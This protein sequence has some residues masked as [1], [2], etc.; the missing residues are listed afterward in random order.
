MCRCVL[1][2]LFIATAQAGLSAPASPAKLQIRLETYLT[3]YTSHRGSPFKAV[4]I[5]PLVEN[6][7]ILIP[8]RSVVYGTVRRATPVRLGIIHERAGLDLNFLRYKTPGGREFPLSAK[9]AAID[10]AREQVT[11]KGRIKGVLAAQAPDEVFNGVWDKPSFGMFFHSLEG[12]RGLSY[13]ISETWPMGPVGPAVLMGVRCFLIRFP[14][15]EIHLPPGTDMT[16][17]VDKANT[18]FAPKPDPPALEPPAALAEWLR[19][20]PSAVEKPD[21]RHVADTINLAF[22]GSRQQLRNAFRVSGWYRPV[23]KTFK[24]FSRFCL[25][26]DRKKRYPRAPVSTLLYRGKPPDLVF[27]KSLDSVAKRDHVRIWSTGFSHGREIWLG[28]ATHDIGVRFNFRTFLFTHRVDRHIDAERATLV[29]DLRFSGCSHA[30][31]YAQGNG[32][33]VPAWKHSPITDGRIAVLSL[34]SCSAPVGPDPQPPP[35]LA[36]NKASRLARRI[37]LETRNYALREN[38][39]YWAYEIIRHR[40]R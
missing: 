31:M 34:Q 11:K 39:Y 35:K 9:L 40:G 24:S 21:G 2:S 38:V 33:T 30:A 27:E 8:A 13:E 3:S 4:V 18:A 7:Q 32:S 17:L 28:A 6:G 37:I 36:G 22:L 15:P 29:T 26:F 12:L 10:N 23:P 1:L 5:S 25:D 16:I 19:S 20:Q 14:E